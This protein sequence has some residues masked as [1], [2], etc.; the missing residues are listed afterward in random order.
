MS[1]YDALPG[2]LSANFGLGG[3]KRTDSV[4]PSS[5]VR[6]IGAD[7]DV[8]DGAVFLVKVEEGEDEVEVDDSL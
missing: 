2:H 3:S 5:R 1:L 6:C 8:S 7:D 4:S